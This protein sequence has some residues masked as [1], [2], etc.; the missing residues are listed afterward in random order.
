MRKRCFKGYP[1]SARDEP[2][3]KA[4]SL[5]KFWCFISAIIGSWAIKG[6]FLIFSTLAS[7]SFLCL[8]FTIWKV[9]LSTHA[10]WQSLT[11]CIVAALATL[12]MSA[13]SPKYCPGPRIATLLRSLYPSYDSSLSSPYGDSRIKGMNGCWC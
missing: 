1:S 5:K 4:T 3:Q 8:F 9:R 10:K 2:L 6:M 7:I 12:L 11:H 13:S